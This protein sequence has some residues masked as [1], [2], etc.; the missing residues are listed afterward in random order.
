MKKLFIALLLSMPMAAMGQDNTWERPEPSA[1]Q[2]NDQKYLVGAVPVVDGHVLFE[3]TIQ[4][5]GKTGRQ[6]Y[7][8][9]LAQLQKLCREPGQFEQSQVSIEDPDKLQPAP[10]PGPY[11]PDVPPDRGLCRR[12]GY[13]ED[14][15]HLLSIRRGA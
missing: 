14:D 2:N 1:Q 6:V 3:T 15:T 7:D 4:A 12:A 5:P 10:E 11:A 9:M 13:R 8:I